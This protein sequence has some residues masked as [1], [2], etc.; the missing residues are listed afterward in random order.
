MREYQ[1]TPSIQQYVILEQDS[2]AAMVFTRSGDIW[3]ARSLLRADTLSMRSIGVDIALLDIYVDLDLP[4][5]DDENDP[6][7]TA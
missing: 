3:D 5:L 6:P 1:A 4:D 7:P 2:V